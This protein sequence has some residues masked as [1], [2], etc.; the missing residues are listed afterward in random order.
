MGHAAWKLS[1]MFLVLVAASPAP[2]IDEL[3]NLGG[4][5]FPVHVSGFGRGGTVVGGT[6][7]PG[8]EHVG[9]V[10]SAG[11]MV[12][13]DLQASVAVGA[14]SLGQ[15]V[16]WIGNDGFLWTN[17]NKVLIT[18]P[19]ATVVN[20]K[21][22]NNAGQVAGEFDHVDGDRRAFSWTAAGGFKDIGSL[23]GSQITVTDITETGLVVGQA[24]TVDGNTH[25]FSWKVG[26]MKDLG[27]LGGSFSIATAANDAG[28]IVGYSQT[29]DF[30]TL[31]FVYKAPKMT[32]LASP[33]GDTMATGINAGGTIAG[34]LLGGGGGLV[35][36][37]A[38]AVTPI[39]G[40]TGAVDLNDAGLVAVEVAT[41]FGR[42]TRAHLWSS[43]GGLVDA[44]SDDDENSVPVGVT[45]D[46]RLIGRRVDPSGLSKGFLSDG[47]TRQY[48]D[49][50]GGG[51]TRAFKINAAGQVIGVS[52]TVKGYDRA[53]LWSGSGPLFEVP[54]PEGYHSTPVAVNAT[55]QVAGTT[56]RGFSFLEQGPAFFWDGATSHDLGSVTPV[57]VNDAGTV[58]G[59][60]WPA[61][62]WTWTGGTF[63]TIV[64]GADV[65]VPADINNA[66]QVV[67]R[68]NPTAFSTRGFSWK[69][70]VF[71]DLGTL[72]GE[73]SEAVAVNDAGQIAGTS[74]T[75]AGL[76]RAFRMVAGHKMTDL[77][78]LFGAAGNSQAS[79]INKNGAVI[80]TDDDGATNQ[81]FLYDNKLRHLGELNDHDVKPFGINDAKDV[82]GWRMDENGSP[83]AWLSKAGAP[84][85][86][87]PEFAGQ[88]SSQAFGINVN[89]D[90]VG[91]ALM[92]DGQRI[93]LRWRTR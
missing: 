85:T 77:G 30:R 78:S 10:W 20:P 41:N 44:G 39:P 18:S 22:V 64:T 66:G 88:E 19:L 25:A 29:A 75:A 52:R 7:Y 58:T 43:A 48:L 34:S 13:V 6:R 53:F 87:L 3:P 70:N 37:P 74:D 51:F 47:T 55:G 27:T 11:S 93:A 40:T 71:T 61:D 17:G 82:A 45:S 67:G 5:P 80:G 21:V 35:W 28:T 33:G 86:H 79:G 16:G 36:S 8:G 54:A 73:N 84:L 68:Y 14:N 4:S 72:G 24:D 56:H 90:V 83:R 46:G 9:F 69:A 42:N 2:G 60:A 32:A 76:R 1:A 59:H 23:G 63:T 65:A 62:G 38:G 91:N 89:G 50:L 92:P 49:G 81:A 57:D 12:E 26:N 15:V 31:A